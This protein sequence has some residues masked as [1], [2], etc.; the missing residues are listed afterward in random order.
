MQLDE[1]CIAMEGNNQLSGIA[2][3]RVYREFRVDK[4]LVKSQIYLNRST[5]RKSKPELDGR[6]S[7]KARF[8]KSH[9]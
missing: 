1:I 5:L 7:R 2:L 8:A 9:A 6:N 3:P 4:N